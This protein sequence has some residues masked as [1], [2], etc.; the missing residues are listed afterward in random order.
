VR[1]NRVFLGKVFKQYAW[2]TLNVRLLK[3]TRLIEPL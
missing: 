2:N 1:R 3:R